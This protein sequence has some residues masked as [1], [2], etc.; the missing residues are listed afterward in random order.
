[1]AERRMFS[2][3]RVGSA[4]FLKMPATSRLFYY[5]LGMNADDDGIV[6]AYTVMKKTGA[7]EDDLKVLL[8]KGFI[9]MLKPDDLIV[10][11]NHWLENNKIRADRKKDSIYKELLL[12]IDPDVKLLEAKK[13]AD[14]KQ[15]TEL[16]NHWTSNGQ[17]RLGK[18]R[19]G[20]VNTLHNTTLQF[21]YYL[22]GK[23]EIFENLEKTSEIEKQITT[24][25]LKNLD[26]LVD[27]QIDQNLT[28]EERIDYAYQY[29]AIKEILS[30]SS[31]A[32]FNFL[33]REL[34]LAKYLKTKEKKSIEETKDFLDYFI[35]TIKK[36]LEEMSRRQVLSN[37]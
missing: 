1:M 7:T 28:E 18:V 20:K 19:L 4:S 23:I 27:I 29:W 15:Y 13:R 3:N 10:Y 34:F 22:I 21:Y 2:N 6:E 17:H 35:K 8:S 25:A 9:T 5:D 16:D 24:N 11:I 37:G 33:T 31:R 32:Y 26:I 12:Q 30:S 14:A 36:E